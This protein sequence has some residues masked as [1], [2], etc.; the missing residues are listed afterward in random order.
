MQKKKFLVINGPNLNMLGVREQTIYGSDTLAD[1]QTF[2]EEYLAEKN[3][4][5]S[6][7]QSNE[8]GRIVTRIHESVS[9]GTEGLIIN[10]GAYSHTSIAILDALKI[11]EF[12]IVEVHLSNTHSR[13]E[14]RSHRLTARSVNGV[15]EGLGKK[16]YSLAALSLL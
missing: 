2:T 12:P 13:E 1:I 9:D 7:F 8:E 11:L 15:I 5:L 10:P 14:F 3:I 6:W 16:V 4:E